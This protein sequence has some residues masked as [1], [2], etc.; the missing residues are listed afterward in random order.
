MS[1][2]RT[3]LPATVCVPGLRRPIGLWPSPTMRRRALR[4]CTRLQGTL[5]AGRVWIAIA[6]HGAAFVGASV[7]RARLG[8]G[9][10]G[11]GLLRVAV[12]GIFRAMRMSGPAGHVYFFALAVTLYVPMWARHGSLQPA[13]VTSRL[14]DSSRR[15]PPFPR[16]SGAG[17]RRAECNGTEVD[18]E[19]RVVAA[20][21]SVVVGSGRGRH[22]GSAVSPEESL[23]SCGAVLVGSIAEHM[24]RL[25]I[26]ASGRR[27]LRIL[28]VHAACVNIGRNPQIRVD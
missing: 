5:A 16:R 23:C 2:H 10:N 24:L 7:G 17:R 1:L 25:A 6:I 27:S 8:V 22:F 11:S 28:G 18:C 15:Q 26:L 14:Q 12:C 13:V 4:A 3:F 20:P 9:G 21:G 19:R